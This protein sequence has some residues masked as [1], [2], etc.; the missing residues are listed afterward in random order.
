MAASIEDILLLKAQQEAANKNDNGA[1]I[2]AG[3]LVGAAG[4]TLAGV[5]VHAG[6]QLINKLKDRLAAGQGLTRSKGQEFR[7]RL[8]PGARMAGGLVGAILGGS[9]GAGVQ[10][11]T[12]QASPAASLLAKLQTGGLTSEEERQLTRVLTETYD[13]VIGA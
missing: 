5:P 13:G 4:G 12:A 11:M 2:T 7:S 8:R 1:A 3:A 9:L 10:Q 6:G